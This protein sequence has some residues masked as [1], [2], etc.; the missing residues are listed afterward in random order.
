MS[1]YK[2]SDEV[3]Q[4]FVGSTEVDEVYVGSNLVYQK[5]WRTTI[6]NGTSGNEA[7]YEEG[8]YGSVSDN[9]IEGSYELDAAY[10]D[11][12]GADDVQVTISLSGGTAPATDYITDAK[13]ADGTALGTPDTVSGQSTGGGRAWRTYRWITTIG[14]KTPSGNWTL[15]L[16]TNP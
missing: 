9:T 14:S 6:T 1:I 7:G 13:F 15:Q 12:T 11:T 5:F 3:T 2:G 4:I 16:R 8:N 10:S